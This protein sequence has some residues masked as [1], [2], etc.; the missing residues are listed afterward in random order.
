MIV[1][2]CA[3]NIA[4][5]FFWDSPV[6]HCIVDVLTAVQDDR[7]QCIIEQ[8]TRLAEQWTSVSGASH[9]GMKMSKDQ[10]S[11]L[12]VVFV[13]TPRDRADYIKS[14]FTDG[15]QP[16]ACLGGNCFEVP[17]TGLGSRYFSHEV[18]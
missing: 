5:V 16:F 10:W 15:S 11:S 18:L 4:S 8:M 17:G 14:T 2:A 7:L 6:R 12:A 13:S 1:R 9:F 3:S